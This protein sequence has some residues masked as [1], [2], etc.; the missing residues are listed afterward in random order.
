MTTTRHLTLAALAI[1]L[2]A[3]SAGCGSA[4][5][6]KAGGSGAPAV[7]RIALADDGMR[8]PVEQPEY[9]AAQVRK[10]SHG[11]VRVEIVRTAA[12]ADRR[13]ERR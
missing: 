6:D 10:L 3:G 8:P 13:S 4:G 12:G 11:S 2:A 9:F 1:A 5:A 7:L